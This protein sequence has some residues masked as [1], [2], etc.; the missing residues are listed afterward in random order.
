MLPIVY[1]DADGNLHNTPRRMCSSLPRHGIPSLAVEFSSPA[2]DAPSDSSSA[3][4]YKL[5]ISSED[6]VLLQISQKTPLPHPKIHSVRYPPGPLLA[7][8]Y[9]GGFTSPVEGLCIPLGGSDN[10]YLRH[11]APPGFSLRPRFSAL[12][13]FDL[14]RP[15]LLVG[16]SRSKILY[17][18]R[19]I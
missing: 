17:L 5:L 6:L 3:L 18:S 2:L 12:A 4:P 1:V 7:H 13:V 8:R 15:W 16:R 11:I 9:L 14:A 10:R 19:S